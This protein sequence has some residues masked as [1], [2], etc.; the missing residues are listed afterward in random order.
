MREIGAGAPV[1]ERDTTR[2]W[3]YDWVERL[4]AARLLSLLHHVTNVWCA[5]K[6]YRSW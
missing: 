6:G 2:I 1:R 3:L 5:S 4:G